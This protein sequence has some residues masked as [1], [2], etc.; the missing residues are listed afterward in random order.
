MKVSQLLEL[1]Q[2]LNPEAT[3]ALEDFEKSNGEVVS[4]TYREKFIK[5]ATDGTDPNLSTGDKQPE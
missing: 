5:L 4:I 1:L 3:I 2:N